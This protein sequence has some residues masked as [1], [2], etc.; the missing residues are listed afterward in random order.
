MSEW[1]VVT[2]ILA[3]VQGSLVAALFLLAIMI[4]VTLLLGVKKLRRR[5]RAGARSLDEL[6]GE[7]DHARMF[8]PDVPRGVI[9]QLGAGT[10]GGR[11]A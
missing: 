6:V 10:S 1:S 9:D 7:G 5:G 2:W 4:G 3:A 11:G 8:P